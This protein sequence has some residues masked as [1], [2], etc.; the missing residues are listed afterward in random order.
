MIGRMIEKARSLDARQI[1]SFTIK[2]KVL[3]YQLLLT[4]L[5]YCCSCC[6]LY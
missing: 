1:L 2:S 6:T 5:P 3:K 4:C